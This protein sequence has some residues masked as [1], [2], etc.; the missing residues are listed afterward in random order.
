[1][2]VQE[3]VLAAF[4]K[5][6]RSCIHQLMEAT[7]LARSELRYGI[8]ELQKLKLIRK[9]TSVKGDYVYELMDTN[10]HHTEPV[11]AGSVMPRY[12]FTI[13]EDVAKSRVCML[14]FMKRK[15]IQEWHPVVDKLLKDYESGLKSIEES[16]RKL[17]DEAPEDYFVHVK[18]GAG[19]V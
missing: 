2:A 1:M 18:T 13:T 17:E 8:V 11:L 10:V 9:V 7:G 4:Q 6:P 15:L 16:R 14:N 12:E 5:K 3:L 19:N